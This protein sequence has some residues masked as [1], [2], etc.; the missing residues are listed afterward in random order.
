MFRPSFLLVLAP[1][2]L[3]G[4]GFGN[5]NEAD[6]SAPAIQITSPDGTV[7]DV[8]DFSANVIDDRGV[9]VVEFYV[10]DVLI[11]TVFT[12][13]YQVRWNTLT[14]PDGTAVLKVVARDFS[15]NQSFISKNVTVANAP[16]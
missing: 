12:E 1:L 15:A 2:V 10:N 5:T 8:V 9:Q 14:V 13:P 4:C 3:A 7:H 6:G 11:G 16:N